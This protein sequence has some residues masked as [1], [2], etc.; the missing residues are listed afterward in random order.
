MFINFNVIETLTGLFSWG[1]IV[2]LAYRI[3]KKQT[4]KPKLWKVLIVLIVGLF[5][6]SIKM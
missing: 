6:F 1:I 2:Y 4:T 3:Y 5:S